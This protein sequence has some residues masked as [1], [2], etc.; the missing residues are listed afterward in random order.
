MGKTNPNDK[1][2]SSAIATLFLLVFCLFVFLYEKY[3]YKEAQSRIEQHALVISNSLWN[4]DPQGAVEYLTL[5]CKSHNYKTI[6]V[7]D[8]KDKLFQK[9][10]NDTDD[11]FE[12]FLTAINLI[13]DVPL[14][15]SVMFNGREIGKIKAIWKCDTIYLELYVLFALILTFLVCNLNINLLRSRN[16]LEKRVKERTMEL[17]TVN[18]SLQFEIEEHLHAREDLY[19][20]EEKYRILIENIPDVLYRT[21]VEGVVTFISRSCENV[22][23][24]RVDELI[25]RQIS[26]V[27]Y[28]NVDKREHFIE[29]IE[30]TGYVNNYEERLKRKDGSIWWA[31]TN[32]HFFKDA[33]GN[34]VGVEGVFRDVTSRKVLESELRQAQKMESIGTLTGGIAHDFNNILGIMIGNAELA[35]DHIPK[36]NPAYAKIEAIKNAG[37]KASIIVRQLL[38]FSRKTDTELKPISLISIIKESIQLLRATIPATIQIKTS[39]PETDI[40]ILGNATQINQIFINLCINASQAIEGMEGVVAIGTETCCPY[41]LA[42]LLDSGRNGFHNPVSTLVISQGIELPPALPIP[43]KTA[44]NEYFH[45]LETEDLSGKFSNLRTGDYVKITVTDTGSGIDPVIIDRIFD[46]YFTTKSIDKGTGMGLAV[47]HG[48]VKNHS[49]V[50]T[51]SSSPSNGTTFTILFPVIEQSSEII[52]D[53]E[54]IEDLYFGTESLLLVDD[55]EFVLDMTREMLERLGYKVEGKTDPQEALE[56][57]RERPGFFDLIITDMTMPQMTGARLAQKTREIRPD[58]PVLICSG[59]SSMIDE[60]KARETGIAAYMMKPI[61][62]Q[63]MGKTIRNVLDRNKT[64]SYS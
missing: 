38:S 20:S 29:V 26:E 23:G 47:V 15:S 11:W 12:N 39:L 46:P 41:D 10:E 49:G 35:I 13:N 43:V 18:A 31:S 58:I 21:D 40:F 42:T 3:E 17:S 37:Q 52:R 61:S 60:D 48:I 28:E 7:T 51:V 2:L 8:T 4:I 53:Q 6:T 24:Y 22:S 16:L 32:A 62:M 54:T 56:L 1:R 33:N 50:I 63:E 36:W 19:K 27:F 9:A 45:T 64:G 5:A 25:G 57:F 30:Q 59:Y 55:D 34:I 44:Q 14:A